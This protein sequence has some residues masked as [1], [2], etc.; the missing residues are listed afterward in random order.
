[1][2]EGG[3][4]ATQRSAVQSA[5]LPIGVSLGSI[6]ATASW[7]LESARRL[8]AAGY[9]GLWSWDHFVGKGDK[10]VPVV[11]QW[12]ILAAAAGATSRI[13]LGTFITNVMNRHP[14]IVARM[15]STL[16][17]ASGGRFTLGVGIGGGAPEHRAYGIDFPEVPERVARLEEAVA[18]IR[19]LWTGGPVTR[20]S[21][22]YPLEAAHAFPVPDPAPRILI[23]ASSKRGLELAARVGDGWA[24]EIDDFERLLPVYRDALAA[25][26][27]TVEEAWIAVGFGGGKSGHDALGGSP[28]VEAPREAWAQYA[29]LGVDEVI[30]SART[31]NDVDALVAARARW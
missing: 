24:A 9:R 19:A 17:D 11:E 23:G 29:E 4:A 13:G 1:L 21:A 6:G 10:T 8:D 2:T 30:V 7:W 31:S 25:E 26:G 18:V 15:A 14:A 5:G 3:R 16:Q 22:F 12:T 28:W 20:P 27:R